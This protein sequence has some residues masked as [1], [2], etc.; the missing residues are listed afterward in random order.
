MRWHCAVTVARVSSSVFNHRSDL[1]QCAPGLTIA[2]RKI[3]GRRTSASAIERPCH[4]P[5]SSQSVL[6]CCEQVAFVRFRIPKM[7]RTSA[8]KRQPP[9]S[10][11]QEFLRKSTV[12]L[13]LLFVV[14]ALAV[15]AAFYFYQRRSLIP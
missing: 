13:I 14:V 15:A 6:I 7:K 11:Y 1:A 9:P 4:A 10:R 8:P 3:K 2:S 12:M 5:A